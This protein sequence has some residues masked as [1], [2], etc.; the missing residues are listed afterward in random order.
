MHPNVRGSEAG[1][2]CKE[3]GMALVAIPDRT[4]ASYWLDVAAEPAAVP[5]KRPVR[6]LLTVRERATNAVVAQFDEMHERQMHLFVVSTDLQ[7]FDHVHP[8]AT[9]DGSFDISLTLPGPG[10]YRLVADLL[11]SGGVPQTLQHTLL[12]SGH[13]L[14]AVRG[15]PEPKA[16]VLEAID[17]GVR[18]RLVTGGARTGDDAH[19]VVE[20]SDQSGAVNDVEPYLGAWGH[21]FLASYDLG[22][23]VHSHPLVEQTDPGGPTITF[24]TLFARSG[25]YRIWTQVQRRGRLLTFA[26]TVRVAPAL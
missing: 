15:R 9:Q 17:G 16:E 8:S 23:V 22:D 18:A 19:V 1:E 21:M 3:C 24:Q 13:G 12:T 11:P 25:W 14:P 10:A 4:D 2:K 20:L 7:F 26:F 6:L 5:V